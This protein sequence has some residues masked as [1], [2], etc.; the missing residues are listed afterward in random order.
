MYVSYLNAFSPSV[1]FLK[2][3]SISNAFRKISDESCFRVTVA[4]PD[5]LLD[6]LKTSLLAATQRRYSLRIGLQLVRSVTTRSCAS[7]SDMEI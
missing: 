5:F 7:M 1:A 4:T 6:D 3:G 2:L